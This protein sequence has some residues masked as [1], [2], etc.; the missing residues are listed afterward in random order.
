MA[1]ARISNCVAGG[2][3]L[4]RVFMFL[5]MLSLFWSEIFPLNVAFQTNYFSKP[6]YLILVVW[7]LY[8]LLGKIFQF[9]LQIL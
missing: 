9:R 4:Y 2:S 5:H 6:T 8:Y 7:L 1:A 3:K